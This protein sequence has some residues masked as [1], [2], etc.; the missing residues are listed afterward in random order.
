M[1]EIIIYSL[2]FGLTMKIA[3]LFDEH[4][5]K[6]FKGDKLVFGILWGF[7]GL[8][9]VLSRIDIANV[10]LAMVL[11]FL[12]RMRLDYR[13]HA[14]ATAMIIIAFVWKSQFDIIIFFIFFATFVIFGGLR[15]YLGDVR[16]KKD[17]L[18]KINE[19]AWYYVIPTAI[20][21]VCT[22]NWVIFVIFTI[23]IVG[24]DLAKYGLLYLKVYN[25]I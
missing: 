22:N 25:K 15:D 8:F 9:L 20:Y 13:N 19:P 24:Y 14:I 23:Y 12:V 10:T 18:Y 3:D 21:G 11:A 2:L 6:W 17:W 4:N 16:K 1:L 7:F 5:M